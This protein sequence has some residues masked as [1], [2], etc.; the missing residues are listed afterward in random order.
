MP[1]ATIN[2]ELAA[3][4]Q[5]PSLGNPMRQSALVGDD[6][7]ALS[8]M[9]AQ[10]QRAHQYN[11]DLQTG[12]AHADLTLDTFMLS[13]ALEGDVDLSGFSTASQPSSNSQGQ[14]LPPASSASI[15]QTQLL[16]GSRS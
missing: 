8:D 7:Q 16:T 4:Q 1:A 14:G 2:R 15:N 12:T 9:A 5:H 13:M 3:G 6:R 10:L 11:Q